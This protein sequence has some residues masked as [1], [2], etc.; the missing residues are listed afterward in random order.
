MKQYRIQCAKCEK[1][2]RHGFTAPSNPEGCV[3]AR[4]MRMS[5]KEMG[6]RFQSKEVE[7]E[8]NETDK[9]RLGLREEK[10]IA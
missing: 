1:S 3:T 9:L 2:L 6:C 10:V 4:I 5:C 8:L 7:V